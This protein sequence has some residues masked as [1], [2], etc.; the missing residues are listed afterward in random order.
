MVLSVES[1]QSSGTPS[2]QS[3]AFTPRC[4]GTG[5]PGPPGPPPCADGRLASD[6]QL[7]GGWAGAGKGQQGGRTEGAFRCSRRRVLEDAERKG[8]VKTA[9]CPHGEG[10]ARARWRGALMAPSH[11]C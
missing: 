3:R 6:P 7:R 10:G 5:P 9:A 11:G 4:L 2:F 1:D 8:T